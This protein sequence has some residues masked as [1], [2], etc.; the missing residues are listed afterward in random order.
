MFLDDDIAAVICARGGYGSIRL[1][2]MVE[3]EQIALHP[4]IF[5]GFSDI[6]TLH[7]ALFSRCGWVTFHGPTVTTL[8]IAD[9]DTLAEFKRALLDSKPQ[10]LTIGQG[11]ALRPGVAQGKLIG[12]NLTTLNHLLG[13]PFAVGCERSILLIEDIGEAPYRVDRMLTQMRM[14]GMFAGLAGVVVGQF[15]DCG[16]EEEI[17]HIIEDRFGD[18]G[19]PISTGWP[20][21]HESRNMTIALGI[22]V[23]LDA[24]R[25][26]MQFL[27]A[28]TRG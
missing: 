18:L 24:D 8:S 2:E 26:E 16:S 4:K 15:K 21:G 5:I 7:A 14:A 19:I 13:T 23:R 10:N 25:G 22:S 3:W 12:G 11:K 6:T 28:A 17:L 1:L 27:E 9:G 20:I